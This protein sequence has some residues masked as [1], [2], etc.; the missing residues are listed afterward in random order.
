MASN[1]T[2][3]RLATALVG[4]WGLA[5]CDSGVDCGPGTMERDGSCVPIESPDEDGGGVGGADAGPIASEDGGAGGATDLERVT[6]W[7]EKTA[8]ACG[9]DVATCVDRMRRTQNDLCEPAWIAEVECLEGV[10]AADLGC[11]LGEPTIRSTQCRDEFLR[12]SLCRLTLADPECYATRCEHDVD[13][14]AGYGCNDATEHCFSQSARC[15]AMPCEHD[16]DCPTGLTCSDAE[17][18]CISS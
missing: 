18:L 12:G 8:P 2:W 14:S 4:L 15:F 9:N 11:E 16:V 6:A 3:A 1:T 7:C 13:C 10:P 5:G 17:G